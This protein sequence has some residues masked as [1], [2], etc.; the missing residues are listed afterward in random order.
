MPDYA[1]LV[2]TLIRRL[3]LNPE[4][5]C[6]TQTEDSSGG[7]LISIKT[8]KEDIGRVIGKRGSTINAI[9]LVTKEAAI[10]SKDRVDVDIDED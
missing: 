1:E 6:V 9:R 10:K 3:V 7:I 5:V 4:A 2:G 8:A